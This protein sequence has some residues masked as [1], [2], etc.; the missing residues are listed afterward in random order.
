[1]AKNP[2]QT[3]KANPLTKFA[4]K[5]TELHAEAHALGLHETGHAIHAAVQKVGWEIVY[6]MKR[7]NP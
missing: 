4:I 2:N 7:E 5:L 1:M 3:T 6:K